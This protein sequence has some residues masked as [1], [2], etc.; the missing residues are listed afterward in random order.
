VSTQ[1]PPQFACPVSHRHAPPEQ[2]EPPKQGCPQAPQL[3]LSIDRLMQVPEQTAVP[4]GQVDWQKPRTQVS[5]AAQV[6]PHPPQLSESDERSTHEPSHAVRPVMHTMPHVPPLHTWPAGHAMPQP[7]QFAPLV[8]VSTHVPSQLVR[9]AAHPASPKSVTSLPSL[10]SASPAS[11]G[12][13]SASV[14]SGTPSSLTSSGPSG[15][16]S[17]RASEPSAIPSENRPSYSP[18][19][20]RVL[21]PQ[22]QATKPTPANRPNRAVRW[23]TMVRLL[24]ARP[25]GPHA[26]MQNPSGPQTNVTPGG[27]VGQSESVPQSGRQ[28]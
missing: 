21:R 3:L 15:V 10:R 27:G 14:A 13:S 23:L 7:P 8:P 2:Y 5:A 26:G 11:A 19:D 25:C 6:A 20:S 16:T 4:V 17:G 1:T 24:R 22:P 28:P 9:P 18:P 12:E